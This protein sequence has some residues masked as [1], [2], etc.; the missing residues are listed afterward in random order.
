MSEIKKVIGLQI[1]KYRE[2]KEMQQ[3]DLA[4]LLSVT[5]G[6]VS[7]WESGNFMPGPETLMLLCDTLEISMDDLFGRAKKELADNGELD[8]DIEDEFKNLEKARQNNLIEFIKKYSDE[9]LRDNEDV[10]RQAAEDGA[11]QAVQKAARKVLIDELN[12]HHQ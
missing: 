11:R 9:V 10:I 8:F 1:K 6:A 3:K 2:K 7:G 5:P 12:R 4:E